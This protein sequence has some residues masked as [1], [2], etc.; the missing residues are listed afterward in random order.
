MEPH[1]VCVLHLEGLVLTGCV[2]PEQALHLLSRCV[3][4]QAR[5]SLHLTIEFEHQTKA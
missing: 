5:P 3:K 1:F 4:L 2:V